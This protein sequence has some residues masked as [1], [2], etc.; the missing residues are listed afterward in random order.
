[1]SI[2]CCL[3]IH[4]QIKLLFS[5]TA[6]INC[7]KN[8]YQKSLNKPILYKNYIVLTFPLKKIA[9]TIRNNGTCYIGCELEPQ[10]DYELDSMAAHLEDTYPKDLSCLSE[11][12]LMEAFTT[13]TNLYSKTASLPQRKRNERRRRGRV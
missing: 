9:G 4:T 7:K 3:T 12:K 5:L 1:M 10:Q 13:K 8:I 11:E 6:K 2:Y